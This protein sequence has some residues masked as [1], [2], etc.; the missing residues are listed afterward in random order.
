MRKNL[1]ILFFSLSSEPRLGEVN[2]LGGVFVNGRPLPTSIRLRIVELC[3]LGVR[4]CDIS[5]QLR[6]S[7]GCVSKI[8]TKF[9]ET[10]SIMPGVIGGSKPRVTTPKIVEQIKIYK[11]QNPGIFAWEIRDR[12]LTDNICDKYNL[13]S[14]S[15]ISRI[16]RTKFGD[17][18]IVPPVMK[19]PDLIYNSSS[20]ISPVYNDAEIKHLA[21][22]YHWR[23][24]RLQSLGHYQ[25]ADD[26][27]MKYA[28]N[29]QTTPT[30]MEL[31]YGDNLQ[32]VPTRMEFK[33]GDN[34]QTVPTR[35]ELFHPNYVGKT[36]LERDNCSTRYPFP[37]RLSEQ[38]RYPYPNFQTNEFQG[39]HSS[40]SIPSSYAYP[41]M[42]TSSPA[43]NNFFPSPSV[44]SCSNTDF[45]SNF[46]MSTAPLQPPYRPS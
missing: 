16:L 42:P 37:G 35:M 26:I 38:S 29:L 4:P 18:T 27:F 5:R 12:L 46:M 23:N 36:Q 7:H 15:S 34:L 2:Q 3:Q 43:T 10:G 44:S 31:K 39:S 13:P 33:Y 32:T 17:K 19:Y 21:S 22:M 1:T 41:L 6:V 40:N 11:E 14:V 8:L 45:S 28:N 24:E 30:R 9:H 25:S 20:G